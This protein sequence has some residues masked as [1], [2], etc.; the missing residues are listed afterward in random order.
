[1][2]DNLHGSLDKQS[3]TWF[4]IEDYLKMCLNKAREENDSMNKDALQTA[5]IRGRIK[6]I[7]ELLDLPNDKPR[8]RTVKDVCGTSEYDY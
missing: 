4:F 5:A 8:D 3:K 1:M 7:K 2:I 6:M